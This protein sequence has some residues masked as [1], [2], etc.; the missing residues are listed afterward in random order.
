MVNEY[1]PEGQGATNKSEME[2]Y[3]VLRLT[4][5]HCEIL[6]RYNDRLKEELSLLKRVYKDLDNKLAAVRERNEDLVERNKKLRDINMK[7]LKK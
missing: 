2:L 4:W 6:Q 3:Q 1:F 7:L 5:A